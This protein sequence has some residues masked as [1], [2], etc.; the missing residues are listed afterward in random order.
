MSN[1]A[2]YLIAAAFLAGGLAW[3]AYTLGASPIWISISVI[4]ILV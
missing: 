2:K 3:T 1:F 4:I